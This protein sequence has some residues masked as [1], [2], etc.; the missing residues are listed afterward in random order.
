MRTWEKLVSAAALAVIVA[1]GTYAYER[2][3]FHKNLNA[4]FNRINVE[5]FDG[6]LSGVRLRWEYLPDDYGQSFDG[7]IVVDT[8][9]N[10]TEPQLDETLKHEACHQFAGVEHQ[11]DEAWQSCMV[12]FETGH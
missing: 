2:E 11:H 10:T 4:R 3:S 12:R 6:S 9:R 5:Y 8:A 1:G 7:E